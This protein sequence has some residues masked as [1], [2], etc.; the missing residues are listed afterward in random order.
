MAK[1]KPES[2]SK[3]QARTAK[4]T[5]RP[6][7]N[8]AT[9][10]KPGDRDSD[11]RSGPHRDSKDFPIV[12]I[13][14]SA[15]GL[16]ALKQLLDALPK[17][18]GIAVVIIQH[19]DPTRKSLMPEL[20][21]SHTSMRMCEV[22]DSPRVLP[23]TVYMIPPGK[24]LSIARG[25]LKLSEPEHPR[26]ARMAIDFFLRSLA[27]DIRERSVGIV[28]SGSGADGTLGI[29]RIK[30]LGGLVV[31]QDPETAEHDSMPR[32][33]IDTGVVD[34]ILP[35]EKMPPVLL[36]YAEHAYI[37][38]SPS[39]AEE[40]GVTQ[41]D[42][43]SPDV[44]TSILSLLRVR[45]KHDFRNYKIQTLMRRMRRRMCL[46]HMDEEQQYLELLREHPE[47]IDALV[48]D[49]LISVTNFFRDEEAWTELR[50]H[51]I[52][53]IVEACNDDEPIRV[54]AAGCATG[55]EPYSIAMLLLEELGSAR[56]LNS[57]QI[58]ASD[59]DRE[60]ARVCPARHL[61]VGDRGRCITGAAQK[62]LHYERGRSSLSRGQ[63]TSRGC[64]IRRTG[65]DR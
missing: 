41:A 51:V 9:P 57:V 28:L 4:N 52:A 42:T 33:A 10:A 6:P 21:S 22:A 43:E 64:D 5:K 1:K 15:G 50:E 3:K 14:A 34:F 2:G 45:S 35:P 18:P 17:D 13:G 11:A 12:G 8:T 44:F 54:W 56:K 48:K 38:E 23:N 61:P 36:S 32:S 19:L 47:E 46:A 30:E 53:P 16:A 24:Y 55:E 63:T 20:L 49:L 27:S 29:K 25:E 62:I 65:S 7:E 26:G 31:V 39:A 37:R 59:I 40:Q 58:F 60:A